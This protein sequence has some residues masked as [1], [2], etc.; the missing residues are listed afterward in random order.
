MSYIAFIKE[1]F[2]NLR[3]VG[4]V[5]RSSKYV[6]EKMVREANLGDSKIVVELG[7]GDG[8]ITKHILKRLHPDARLFAFEFNSKFVVELNQIEDER[9]IVV[10]RDVVDIQS[11]LLEYEVEKVD[12]IISAIPFVLIPEEKS[13]EIIKACKKVLKNGGRFVQLHYSLMIKKMYD[14]LFDRVSVGFVMRNVPPAWI[15]TCFN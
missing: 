15:F 2:T 3:T 13:L 9:L 1:S 10:D 11:I 5:T 8:V 7:A 6:C 12:H 14:N 4:T